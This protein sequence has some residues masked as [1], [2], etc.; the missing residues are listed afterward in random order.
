MLDWR[1]AHRSDCTERIRPHRDRV[2]RR[3]RH[4]RDRDRQ[5]TGQRVELARAAGFVR[6]I[7]QGDRGGREG[8]RRDLRRSHVHRRRRH[9]RIRWRRP[10]G[11]RTPRSASCDGGRTDPRD[12]RDPRHRT[13]W[14]TRNCA[15]CPLSRRSVIG[16]ARP[17]RGQPRSAP[18]RRRHPAAP[19]PDRRAQGTGDDDVGPPHRHRRGTRVGA[20]RRR[21]RRR[22]DGTA[23][24]RRRVRHEGSRRGLAAAACPRPRRQG[25][26]G[27][28]QHRDVRC[29]PSLDRPEDPWIPRA[30]VHHPVRGGGSEPPLRGGHQGR[31][32]ALH[33]VGHRP[34]VGRAALLVLRRARRQ[35]DPRH[36][37]G[38]AD[39]RHPIP[40]ACSVRAR[41]VAASR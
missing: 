37:Q 29:V 11:S 14:R 13:R 34:A 39:H 17:P 10:A 32:A 5:S 9:H 27:E 38:H 4:R 8:C 2:D 40:A 6:R 12:R 31:G 33:G 26:R 22:P 25:R 18:R 41:W 7:G 23:R 24:G 21:G 19:A 20:R 3:R 28:G 1:H 16:E 30:G 35:Q 36:R 15:G